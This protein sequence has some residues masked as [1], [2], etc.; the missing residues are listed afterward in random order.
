QLWLK[1]GDNVVCEVD[2]IGR[3]ENSVS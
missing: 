1:A 2:G 3:L